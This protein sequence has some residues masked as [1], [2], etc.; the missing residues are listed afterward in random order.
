MGRIGKDDVGGV[1]SSSC[2]VIGNDAAAT[3]H[4]CIK[5]HV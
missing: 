3:G 4:R 1:G 2:F 5:M